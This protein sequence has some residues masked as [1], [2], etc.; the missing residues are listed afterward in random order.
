MKQRGRWEWLERSM[1]PPIAPDAQI[2]IRHTLLVLDSPPCRRSRKTDI[3]GYQSTSNLLT[4]MFTRGDPHLCA[5]KEVGVVLI[6]AIHTDVDAGWH[7]SIAPQ[8]VDY[9]A[10]AQRADVVPVRQIVLREDALIVPQWLVR[11]CT[12][13]RLVGAYQVKTV[14]RQVV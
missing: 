10:N 12:P 11:T 5:D 8:V 4:A 7:L 14:G 1:I 6:R 13:T 2:Q 3:E 9:S